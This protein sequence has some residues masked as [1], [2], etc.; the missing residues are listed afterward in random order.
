MRLI[1]TLKYYL[2]SWWLSS[3]LYTNIFGPCK[4]MVK[5]I[6]DS[7]NIESANNIINMK[8]FKYIPLSYKKKLIYNK[9]N[10]IIK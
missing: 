5:L 7:D 1:E 3:R 4:I 2:A 9:Y 6:D 10:K 8:A